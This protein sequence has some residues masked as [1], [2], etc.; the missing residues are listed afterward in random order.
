MLESRSDYA[1][2]QTIHQV[3]VHP[4]CS[5]LESGLVGDGPTYPPAENLLVQISQ[6]LHALRSAVAVVS[7][8]GFLVCGSFM[9]RPHRTWASDVIV[10]D[11]L[12]TLQDTAHEPLQRPLAKNVQIERE[13]ART[14]PPV[15]P[16]AFAGPTEKS[17]GRTLKISANVE[18]GRDKGQTFG[19][20][21]EV[22]NAKGRVVAGAG[23]QDVYN[24]RFRTG[25][26]TLQFFVRPD[27][28]DDQFKIER[29]PHP[30]LGCGVYLCDYDGAVYAWT[31][32][33]K[34]S[35][36]RW[37]SKSRSWKAELPPGMEAVRSGDGI[38]PLGTGR[39]VFANNSAWYNDR[40]ILMPP[41]TGGYF[42]FYYADGHL[43]FYHRH[44]AENG[45][46]TRLYAC[47]WTPQ[48]AGPVDLD[49]AVVLKTK[50]DQ[51]TPFSWGHYD[52]QVLTVSNQGGTYV[53][54][55]NRW[56]TILEADK[57]FSYQV[58]SALYW[59]DRL[60]LAQYP[61]G[62]LFE[63]SGHEARHL[64]DWPPVLP[65]VSS[66]SRECQ[67]LSIYRGD[68]LAGVWPWAELWRY[69]RGAKQ[70]HTMGR[71]FS[72]PELTDE[73][74]HPYE[75]E[76]S[77]LKLVT[78]HWGQRITSMVPQGD[79]VYLSTSSKGTSPWSD[80]YNFLNDEQ[81]RE[82]GAVLRLR[83]PGNLATQMQWKDSPTRF[84]FQLSDGRM[85][86]R[87]D[88]KLLASSTLP[89]DFVVD[90]SNITVNRSQ[91]V[92]GPLNGKLL[93]NSVKE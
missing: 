67:T 25:R 60:L 47:P 51:E 78:N 53:F 22:K 6:Y 81:R 26:H 84:E 66:S 15:I 73:Q 29:L 79:A 9:G 87:Q 16:V 52:D 3:S 90:L 45:S 32:A 38:M 55:G 35:V 63:Y 17:A 50:Y 49:T 57:R 91:G 39:L 59:H 42:N 27:V 80:R 24:T 64:A 19:S 70:W 7:I 21:F 43:F 34:N 23:F 28:G 33:H 93:S 14:G 56:R 61:T 72:H 8:G 46:F 12:I 44:R 4:Y 69:E 75:A 82:Y 58:Y 89:K 65:G 62:N 10:G 68:L 88:G 76:A 85:N 92:F 48:E 2:G 40:Q 37:D 36:R 83:M 74:T 41:D 18:F 13:A 86:I 20:L 11:Q 30:D 1:E 71:M 54:A 77:E 5:S 31:S